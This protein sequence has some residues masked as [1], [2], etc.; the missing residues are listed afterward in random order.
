VGPQRPAI[1]E[2]RDAT[3]AAETAADVRLPR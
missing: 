2:D 3:F 1:V